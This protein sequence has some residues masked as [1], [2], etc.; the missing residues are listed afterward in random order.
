[1]S[2]AVPV[3]H[4]SRQHGVPSFALEVNSSGLPLSG[5]ALHIGA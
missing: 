5:S 3:T 1:L 4:V 2:A